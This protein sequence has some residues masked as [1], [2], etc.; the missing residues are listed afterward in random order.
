MEK[1]LTDWNV[2]D[3]IPKQEYR[4]LMYKKNKIVIIMKKS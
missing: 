2:G 3:D 4:R 1:V